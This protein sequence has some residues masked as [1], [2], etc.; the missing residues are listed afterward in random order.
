MPKIEISHIQKN[1]RQFNHNE[2]DEAGLNY[3]EVFNKL[4]DCL[5][6]AFIDDKDEEDCFSKNGSPIIIVPRT[7]PPRRSWRDDE[8]KPRRA[9]V[10]LDDMITFD[11]GWPDHIKDDDGMPIEPIEEIKAIVRNCREHVNLITIYSS[12]WAA[13]DFFSL[14]K[15]SGVDPHK[16]VSN[17]IEGIND[18]SSATRRRILFKFVIT[19]GTRSIKRTSAS[20]FIYF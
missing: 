12:Y 6:E 1:S 2:F 14:I 13:Y 4:D 7:W 9:I 18:S 15:K 16:N 19:R 11:E 10:Y 5:D 3:E 8:I 17:L 20:K